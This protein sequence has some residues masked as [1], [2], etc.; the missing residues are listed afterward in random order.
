M[1]LKVLIF[2]N[3]LKIVNAINGLI[4]VKSENDFLPIFSISTFWFVKQN[5]LNKSRELEI[6]DFQNQS[7]KLGAFYVSLYSL[8]ST[9]G[10]KAWILIIIIKLGSKNTYDFIIVSNVFHPWHFCYFLAMSR[11]KTNTVLCKKK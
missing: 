2:L 7:V 1:F 11:R 5:W 4:W 9:K 3:I 8:S 10:R 6:H